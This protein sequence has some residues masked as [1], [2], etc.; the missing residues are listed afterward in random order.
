VGAVKNETAKQ[1]SKDCAEE[2][3]VKD[4]EVTT[5]EEDEDSIVEEEDSIVEE[6]DNVVFDDDEDEHHS[7]RPMTQEYPDG[8]FTYYNGLQLMMKNQR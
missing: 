6:E 3:L 2:V 8:E 4:G 5:E 1:H 7:F